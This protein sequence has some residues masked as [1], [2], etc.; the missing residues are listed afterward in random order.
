[1]SL[2][3]SPA[4]SASTAQS[5]LDEWVSFEDLVR[6]G[7]VDNWQTIKDWQSDPRIAFPKGRLFGPNSRRWLK[8]E[9][10]KWLT[11][12]PVERAAFDPTWQVP[13]KRMKR[14][15]G[16]QKQIE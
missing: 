2:E 13:K 15:R 16:D 14:V 10:E 5:S 1:M 8:A 11:T 6:A 7:I 9:I 12:R 3:H 4:R